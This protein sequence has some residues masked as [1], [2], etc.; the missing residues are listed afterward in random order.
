MKNVLKA[1]GLTIASIALGAILTFL[2]GSAVIGA[3]FVLR[4]LLVILSADWAL[5]VGVIFAL[6]GSYSVGTSVLRECGKRW[7]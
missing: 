5:S 4:E 6:L 1:I 7:I 2:V 3:V